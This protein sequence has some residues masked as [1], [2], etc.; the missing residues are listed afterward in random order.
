MPGEELPHPDEAAPSVDELYA[1]AERE[2][3]DYACKA[4]EA[5]E[6]MDRWYAAVKALDAAGESWPQIAAR[7][8]ISKSNV[9]YMVNTDLDARRRR[10]AKRR[11]DL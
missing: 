6:Q 5:E 7:L 1:A 10:R 11:A 8:G 2:K 4:Q 9:Q 3:A